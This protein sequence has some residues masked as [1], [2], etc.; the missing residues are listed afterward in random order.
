MEPLDDRELGELLGTWQAPG[1]P[2]GMHPPRRVRET[3]WQWLIH[4]SI[5][6]PVPALLGAMVVVAAAVW[7]VAAERRPATVTFREFQPVKEL[8]MRVIRSDYEGQ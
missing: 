4:G 6:I 2:A 5:R 8:K 7:W 1:A 3:V